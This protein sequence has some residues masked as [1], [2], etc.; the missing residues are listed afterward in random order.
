MKIKQTFYKKLMPV[1]KIYWHI[2]KPRSY[3]VK[4]LI[5]HPEEARKI[6]LVLHSY[7]DTTLWNIPGEGY[8]PKKESAENAAECEMQEELNLKVSN[9]STIGEYKTTGEG[10]QDTVTIFSGT[11]TNLLELKQSSEISQINWVN[12][13]TVS[14]RDDIARVV[15][16]ARISWDMAT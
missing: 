3:G 14:T 16:Q 5:F 1:T 13:D 6:L 7:G 8:N 15:N 12:I 2:F 9:L 11:A 10:K 4:V